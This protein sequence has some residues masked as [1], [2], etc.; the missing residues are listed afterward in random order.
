MGEKI[1]TKI[2]ADPMHHPLKT[3]GRFAIRQGYRVCYAFYKSPLLAEKIK[4]SYTARCKEL[5]VQGKNVNASILLDKFRELDRPDIYLAETELCSKKVRRLSESLNY[6]EQKSGR[7]YDFAIMQRWKNYWRGKLRSEFEVACAAHDESLFSQGFFDE[8]ET[9][10]VRELLNKW[11]SSNTR[12]EKDSIADH[13]CHKLVVRS[14]Q[15]FEEGRKTEGCLLDR[16]IDR[17]F[18]RNRPITN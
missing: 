10:E 16:W 4:L 3:V 15:L 14:M 11:N 9:A 8:K 17:W 5:T 7:I 6:L 18:E 1:K 2:A 12:E 13:I